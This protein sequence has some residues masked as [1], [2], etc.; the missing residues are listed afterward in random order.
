MYFIGLPPLLVCISKSNGAR[1]NRRRARKVFINRSGGGETGGESKKGLSRIYPGG[2]IEGLAA[3]CKCWILLMARDGIEP[4]TH[5]FSVTLA[6][7]IPQPY[8]ADTH[9]KSLP[10][11]LADTA[12]LFSL[13][14]P[15]LIADNARNWR[16]QL[17]KS[18]IL[19]LAENEAADEP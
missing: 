16:S 8:L 12:G 10:R 3:C 19:S 1:S 17:F 11:Y 13:C 14:C 6:I 9:R 2:R 18:L 5:G 4:P 15:E 7:S